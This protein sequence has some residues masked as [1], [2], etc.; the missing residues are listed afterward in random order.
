MS[1]DCP[2]FWLLTELE[3]HLVGCAPAQHQ[4]VGRESEVWGNSGLASA[5]QPERSSCLYLLHIYQILLDPDSGLAWEHASPRK[6][7]SHETDSS[8]PGLQASPSEVRLG[9]SWLSAMQERRH[10]MR[11]P[12]VA[13]VS[14]SSNAEGIVSRFL[15]SVAPVSATARPGPVPRRDPGVARHVSRER[16]A[17]A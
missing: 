15:G 3:P 13:H 7:P 14:L 11:T 1:R 10:R 9:G 16:A 4:R 17:S 12:A 5:E 6:R 8:L 2:T